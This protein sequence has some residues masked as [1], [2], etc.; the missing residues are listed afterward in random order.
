ML[1]DLTGERRLGT[2]KDLARLM[3]LFDALPEVDCTLAS[4]LPGD[5]PPETVA[6][7]TALLAFENSRKHLQDS[8]RSPEEVPAL[9]EL[10][11]AIAGAP[12]RQRPIYSVYNCTVAPLQHDGATT[13]A[14]LRLAAAGVPVFVL[15]MPQMATSAPKSVLG[16][17]I[18][19]LAELLSAVVFFQL[20][21][22]GCQMVSV[23]GGAATD[24]RSGAYMAGTPE[25]ALINV[26][27]IEMSRFYGLPVEGSAV[28]C[29]SRACDMQAGIESAM[30][31]MACVLAG[32]DALLAVGL[33]D[34]ARTASLAKTILDV[35]TISAVRR[36]ARDDVVDASS[37]LVD[38]ILAVGVGGDYITRPSSRS[39]RGTGI[40]RPQVWSRDQVG[41]RRADDL[42]AEAAARAEELIA[43]HVV[44]PL[45]EDVRRHGL[46]LIRRRQESV[47]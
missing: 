17:S 30:T 11:E 34:G 37:T 3:R 2:R 45:P 36:F 15:P 41:A 8:A 47:A 33:V 12:L 27:C 28:T 43:S 20:V 25:A 13:K 4:V 7:E 38:D 9:L 21:V 22:P 26:A 31:G 23:V 29:D 39:D 24:L 10:L 19:N 40:W 35:D 5:A 46:E 14:H 18:I 32:A 44:A 16:T 1:D 6:L 42:I